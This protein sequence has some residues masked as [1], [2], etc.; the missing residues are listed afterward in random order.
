MPNL[1]NVTIIFLS[2]TLIFVSGCSTTEFADSSGASASAAYSMPVNVSL[3][4]EKTDFERYQQIKPNAI[5]KVSEEPVSTFSIDVDTAAYSNIR[6]VLNQ[7]RVPSVDMVRTEELVNYF[8]YDYK[9]PDSKDLPFSVATEIAPTPWNAKSYLLNIGIKGFDVDRSD[10]PPANLVFLIDVSGS[11]SSTYKLG[12]VKKSFQ[13][14]TRQ[15][16]EKDS[17]AIVVYAGAAG[18]VLPPTSGNN[19]LAINTA[20]EN[21]TAGGSTNGGAGIRLAYRLA[22]QSFIQGGINRVIIASDGDMNVG[23]INTQA[24]LDLVKEKKKSGVSLTTLGYGMGNYNSHL[25]EQL[26]DVGN[27]NAA[28]IDN[29][30]E[31]QKV[32]VEEMSSTLFTIA[33][34]VKVQI[35]FSPLVSEYRLIGYENRLLNREDFNNDNVDAGDIG[36]GHTVTA[37]YE[38]TLAQDNADQID[39]LRYTSINQPALETN[40]LAFLKLRYKIPNSNSS[41]S[42][43]VNYPIQKSSI[44][45]KIIESSTD[46]RFSAAVAAFG[47]KLR[48]GDY[49]VDTF[50]YKD[51]LSL[52]RQAKGNDANGYRGEF[53]QLLNLAS[54]L[55]ERTP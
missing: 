27:G 40:E 12:L 28:Y 17:V 10:L 30:R 6:R 11:M 3:V 34:D 46:F 54:S 14:L 20:L 31:S 50:S 7:G 32:L 37:I 4:S 53:I 42:K 55:A 22:Q 19:K 41:A 52:A 1:V 35:E 51:I 9:Q 21:L 36:A 29:L 15:L 44:Q 24:L 5:K 39:P 13:M 48:G 45:K 47:Q 2:L 43:L 16:D 25:M 49:L 8:Q 38:I 26:A 18:M 23:T 33:K